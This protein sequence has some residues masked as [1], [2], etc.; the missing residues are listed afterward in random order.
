MKLANT[1]GNLIWRKYFSFSSSYLFT[2][3]PATLSSNEQESKKGIQSASKG[4]DSS[5]VHFTQYPQETDF[6]MA[7]IF[8]NCPMGV[9]LILVG[10]F[11]VALCS[12][13]SPWS[14]VGFYMSLSTSIAQHRQWGCQ[15]WQEVPTKT[16]SITYYFRASLDA[17]H[18]LKGSA[19]SM[20]WC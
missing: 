11:I 3:E 14:L 8:S 19:S 1:I 15:H 7:V 18:F 2:N 10:D 6:I 4:H 13:F 16:T 17:L 20:G 12:A 9:L 5:R